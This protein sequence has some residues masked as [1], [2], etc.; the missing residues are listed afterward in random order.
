MVSVWARAWLWG[1][2]WARGRAGDWVTDCLPTRAWESVGWVCW[3]AG[4]CLREWQGC[5]WAPPLTMGWARWSARVWRWLSAQ[6][7]A[8][9]RGRGGGRP[10][11]AGGGWGGGGPA[12]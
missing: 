9:G 10:A 5:Q 7:S 2:A 6:L 4:G 1:L 3:W 11:L 8:R 12:P